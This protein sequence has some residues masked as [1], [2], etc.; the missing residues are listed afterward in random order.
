MMDSIKAGEL[1]GTEVKNAI[2]I[3]NFKGRFSK[4]AGVFK[5]KERS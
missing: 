3:F 1:N 5:M 4:K 2:L